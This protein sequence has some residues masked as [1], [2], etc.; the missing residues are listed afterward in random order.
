MLI[1]FIAAPFL[2]WAASD[3]L[4]ITAIVLFMLASAGMVVGF[5]LAG[6]RGGIFLA[7]QCLVDIILVLLA[8]GGDVRIRR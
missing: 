5:L 7:G 3:D 2:L 1:A 6:P 8:F 4:S